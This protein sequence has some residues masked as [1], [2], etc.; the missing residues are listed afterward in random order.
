M[1]APAASMLHK[2]LPHCLESEIQSGMLICASGSPGS[3]S[4]STMTGSPSALSSIP[5]SLYTVAETAAPRG[6]PQLTRDP[7]PV[8]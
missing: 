7:P 3:S 8:D 2:S 1:C 6:L 4:S 5:S